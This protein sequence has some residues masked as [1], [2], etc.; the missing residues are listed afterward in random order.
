MNQ[1]SQ[2]VLSRIGWLDDVK[3]KPFFLLDLL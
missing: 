2:S 1:L 3:N